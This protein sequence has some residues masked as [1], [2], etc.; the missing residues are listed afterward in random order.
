MSDLHYVSQGKY[1]RLPSVIGRAKNNIFVFI[2]E[3]LNKKLVKLK[4]QDAQFSWYF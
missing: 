1:L 4:R 3:K 2:S